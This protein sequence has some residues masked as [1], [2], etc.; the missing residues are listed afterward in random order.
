ML[1]KHQYD[2]LNNAASQFQNTTEYG[3]VEVEEVM[4]DVF[5]PY[6]AREAQPVV[7]NWAKYFND[8][9]QALAEPDEFPMPQMC[10]HIGLALSP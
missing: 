10:R 4:E 7:M 1:S 8:L 9:N 3:L 2:I 6:E 5:G